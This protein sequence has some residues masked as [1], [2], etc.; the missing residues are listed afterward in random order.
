MR[1]FGSLREIRKGLYGERGL[2]QPPKKEDFTLFMAI[3]IGVTKA[4]SACIKRKVD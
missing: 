4:N 1:C 3:L 2:S